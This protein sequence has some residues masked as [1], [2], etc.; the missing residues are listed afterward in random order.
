MH[1]LYLKE[2]IPEKWIE[3]NLSIKAG[4]FIGRSIAY[5]KKRR[6]LHVQSREQ[7]WLLAPFRIYVKSYEDSSQDIIDRWGEDLLEDGTRPLVIVKS[8]MENTCPNGVGHA[9]NA[10]VKQSRGKYLCF[11]DADDFMMP[12]RVSQQWKAAKKHPN[13]IIGCKFQRI[14]PS[15]TTRFTDWANGLT[16]E[17]LYKQIYLS[18]GPTLIM[19]TWFCS[20]QVFDNVGGFAETGKG[21]PEDL[22]FF[23]AH[24][25][26]GGGLHRVDECLLV[27]RH[28]P[29]AT[30]FSIS[31]DTIWDLRIKRL[32]RD[33]LAKYDNFTIWNAGKQG[34]KLYRSLT[35]ANRRKVLCFCDVDP[36]K[37]AKGVYIFQES[38]ETPKPRIPIVH[39]SQS[40]KPFIICVKLDM[41]NGLLEQNLASLNLVEGQDYHHFN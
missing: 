22:I 38:K 3:E 31:E 15:S 23:Y 36:K 30:T 6:H 33:V 9:K 28:H 8:G 2:N 21:T 7:R 12:N 25:D 41:T 17:Q 11:L 18:H 26:L 39:F 35:E 13:S 5:M 19:P 4:V 1:N 10:A 29:E 32:E 37:I 16:Q 20:R 27:Y 24:L 14:P 34:R 40:K